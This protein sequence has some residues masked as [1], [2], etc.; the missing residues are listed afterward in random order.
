[1]NV[2]FFCTF[3]EKKKQHCHQVRDQH[4]I[5]RGQ[6]EVRE[7][8]MEFRGQ[9]EIRGQPGVMKGHPEVLARRRSVESDSG[10]VKLPGIED[11]KTRPGK[12]GEFVFIIC[13]NTYLFST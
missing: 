13:L 4:E 5:M 3:T 10:S 8:Q 12:R 7:G 2:F 1:M 11:H 6:G 9:P